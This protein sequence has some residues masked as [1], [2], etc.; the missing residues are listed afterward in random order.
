MES[1]SWLLVQSPSWLV[2]D[3]WWTIR[4]LLLP[5]RELLGAAVCCWLV[6]AAIWHVPSSARGLC[7]D[8]CNRAACCWLVTAAVW[9]VPSFARGLC[10]KNPR[11]ACAR[12]RAGGRWGGGRVDPGWHAGGRGR[13]ALV[14]DAADAERLE[15]RSGEVRSE[16]GDDVERAVVL[17]APRTSEP[18]YMQVRRVGVSAGAYRCV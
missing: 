4:G 12:R 15:A 13:P 1:P 16:A 11:R 9:H 7:A 10:A 5:V 18:Q 6:T 2:S 17:R 3:C 8:A 14:Y